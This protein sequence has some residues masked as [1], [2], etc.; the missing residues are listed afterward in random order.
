MSYTE[1][2]IE[3]DIP[4]KAA[5]LIAQIQGIVRGRR[6]DNDAAFIAAVAVAANY[7]YL[8]RRTDEEIIEDFK[9]W[10]IEYRTSGM[11]KN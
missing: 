9:T 7:G 5:W 3:N 2:Q 11:T 4:S 6:I 1:D 10:L 8:S